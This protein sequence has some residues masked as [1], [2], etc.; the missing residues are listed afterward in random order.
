M[1]VAI[2]LPTSCRSKRN[3]Q[4]T[5]RTGCNPCHHRILRGVHRI[6]ESVL[7]PSSTARKGRNFNLVAIKIVLASSRTA[8]PSQQS[9]LKKLQRG[10]P[11]PGKKTLRTNKIIK[12]NLHFQKI[13]SSFFPEPTKNADLKNFL[14]GLKTLKDTAFQS[15]PDH[16]H[17][18]EVCHPQEKT[19]RHL[20]AT[21]C[22]ARRWPGP[23]PTY[24]A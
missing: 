17:R 1:T 6:V 19:H 5:P 3:V 14:P 7:A 21:P 23:P 16:E 2:V 18:L 15:Y 22:S 11:A 20:H 9:S 24:H 8:T 12:K 13:P 10:L 4:L